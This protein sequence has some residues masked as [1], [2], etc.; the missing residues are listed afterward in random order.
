MNIV[1]LTSGRSGS[2]ILAKMLRAMGWSLPCAD[3]E[4]AEHVR[5]REVSDKIVRG[6]PHTE[7][8]L[9]EVASSL[10]PEPWVLKD[11]RLVTTFERWKPYLDD[12]RNLL[13]WLH[14]D[15]VAVE[16]S[17]TK[18]RWGTPSSRGLLIRGLTIPEI[19][20]ACKQYLDEWS[21]PTASVSFEQVKAAIQLF[22]RSRG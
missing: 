14:R 1:I 3:D 4:Y 22:D 6:K 16:K 10:Q 20:A 2:T 13:L 7:S 11:P 17:L 19:E 9:A 5:F 8:M 12:G 18:K 15:R 21:G